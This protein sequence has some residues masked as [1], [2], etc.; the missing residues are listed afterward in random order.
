MIR[1][2]YSIEELQTKLNGVVHKNTAHLKTS[3]GFSDDS[4]F[5]GQTR[6]TFSIVLR[7][8]DIDSIQADMQLLY[9][10]I[11]KDINFLASARTPFPFDFV[12]IDAFYNSDT[13]D[14]KV[15]EIN[16]R[17]AG[18]H[19]IGEYCDQSVAEHLEIDFNEKLNDK[20]VDIQKKMQEAVVGPIESLLYISKPQ[21]PKWLY[22]EA[23]E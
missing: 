8:S 19:E 10:R 14:L 13:S 9:D 18:M 23:I 16:G 4:P 11:C 5:A 3:A 22:Y 20:I 17:D 15:L 7:E 6:K 21:K 1:T 12:R 2:P